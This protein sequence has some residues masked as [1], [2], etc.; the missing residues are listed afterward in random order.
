MFGVSHERKLAKKSWCNVCHLR[1]QLIWFPLFGFLHCTPSA[2]GAHAAAHK[3]E[4]AA[5]GTEQCPGAHVST[6]H[7]AKA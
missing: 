6:A 2:R 7:A 3:A 5:S 4:T 1:Q